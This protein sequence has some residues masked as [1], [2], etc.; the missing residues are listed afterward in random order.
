MAFIL[1]FSG[2]I[3]LAGVF[4][5]VFLDVVAGF[6][7]WVGA[8]LGEGAGVALSEAVLAGIEV[9]FDGFA[10]AFAADL[11]FWLTVSI[12]DEV[13]FGVAVFWLF[14][15]LDAGV[16]GGRLVFLKVVLTVGFLGE[17][18]V[19][20]AVD[21]LFVTV[22]VFCAVVFEVGTFAVF[23]VAAAFVVTGFAVV[24]LV[25]VAFFCSG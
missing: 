15:G 16:L 20:F 6:V 10:T 1:D 2:A 11:D 17:G 25:G 23:V 3:A 18:V 8:F 12:V 13:F 21:A 24:F 9:V 4:E 22:L 5:E 19:F 7:V 14:S